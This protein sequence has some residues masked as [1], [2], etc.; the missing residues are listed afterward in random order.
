MRVSLLLLAALV[1]SSLLLARDQHRAPAKP[2]EFEIGQR[3]FFDFGP[4]FNF[5]ELLVVRPSQEGSAV[6]RIL[7]TPAADKCFAPAKIEY[8]S[9]SLS[10]TPET[11]LADMS[12]CA[13]PEKDLK[14]KPK[15]CNHCQ[16]FSG[17]DTAIRVRCGTQVRIVPAHVFEDYWFNPAAVPPKGTSTMLQLLKR[18]EDALGPGVMEKPVLDFSHDQEASASSA[19]PELF[20]RIGNG[21]Y[22][23]LFRKAP[24]KPSDLYRAAHASPLKP[25]VR[26]ATI[27]PSEPEVAVMPA[28][29]RLAEVAK[30]AGEVTFG[31]QVNQEGKLVNVVFLTGN[32]FLQAAVGDAI[33]SWKFPRDS[34]SQQIR[35]SISFELNCDAH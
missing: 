7:L 16:H 30:I 11:L 29:R 27:I 32:R 21:E 12:P 34:S 10:D 4:P 5:Y 23:D 20:D 2:N 13:I 31:A 25:T 28:Y 1:F 35:A 8:V 24:E 22:D 19:D 9:A 33:K 14:R 3:T 18:L 17:A 6:E 15:D 26:L